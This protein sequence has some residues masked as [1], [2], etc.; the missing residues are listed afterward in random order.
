MFKQIRQSL[1][2]RLMMYFLFAGLLFVLLFGI[3]FAHGIKVHFKQEIL[4]NIDQYLS[5]IARDIG[6]PPDLERA[7]RLTRN[8]SFELRISGPGINWRSH[9]NI[10]LVSQLQF[11]AAPE[12]Y[13]KYRI[14]RHKR[15]NYVVLQAGEYEYM[16]VMGTLFKGPRHQRNLGFIVIVILS[17]LLL[18]WLIRR[19]LKPLETIAQG[20]ER[21][22]RGVLDT[23]IER[24]GSTEFKQLSEGINKMALEIESMLQGKQQ[25]LLAISHELRSPL[26][27][28][29]VN[30]ELMPEQVSRQALIEDLNEMQGLITLILESERLD[31]RHAV[32]NKTEIEL[33]Q[34]ITKVIQQFFQPLQIDTELEALSIRADTTRLS[35]LI[36]N[37]LDNALKFSSQTERPPVIRCYRDQTSIC[38][39][40]EDYGCGM[41]QQELEQISMAF[42]RADPARQRTTGGFGLGL[43][44]CR[45]IVQAHGGKIQFHSQSGQGTRVQVCLPDH[46]KSPPLSLRS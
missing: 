4:P 26:T 22:G 43:Y 28:A 5:Y 2:I 27:R 46:L 44:L 23:P 7:E 40:V 31:Q 33:D 12:P 14:A 13:H 42:Y 29:K 21:I 10:P 45:L 35:L 18:F 36:K 1:I 30:V 11:E 6:S 24:R 19:S 34:L 17:L 9:E 32:L 20:V 16:Y 37:L 15:N 41:N 39:E 25:L 38:L 8:L 3:K